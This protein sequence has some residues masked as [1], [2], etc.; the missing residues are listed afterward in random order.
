VL[1]VDDMA[2][3]RALIS[4]NLELEGF[5][6]RTAEDGMECLEM[7]DDVAPDLI[8]LDV[9]MK[10]LDG[11]STAVVLRQRASTAGIPLVIV[12]ARAQGFDLQRGADIGVDAY[13]TKPFEPAELVRTV[14]SLVMA[15]GEGARR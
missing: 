14:R 13:L 3:I 10:G 1:V 12:T 4:I 9:A 5:E 7:V 6:V 2:E 8:T 11:F 15:R